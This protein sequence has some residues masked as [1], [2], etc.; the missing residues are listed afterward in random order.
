MQ[1]SRAVVLGNEVGDLLRQSDLFCE[2]GAVGYMTRDNL[3]AL[4]RA[5]PIV[6]IVALLILDEILRR[7]QFS[8]VVI[9]RADTREQGIGADCAT[10]VLSE[11]SDGV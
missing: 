11:L 9:E 7:R 2:P 10:R 5:Q 6:R 1:R 8:D 4:V 3:R